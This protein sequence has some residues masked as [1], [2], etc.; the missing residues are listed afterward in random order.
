MIQPKSVNIICL[1]SWNKRIFTP[2]WVASEL[3]NLDP[4]EPYNGTINPNELEFGFSYRDITLF[5]K[6]NLIEIRL[7]KITDETKLFSVELFTR[8]MK[9]LPHTPTKGVGVNVRYEIEENANY[10]ILKD[11]KKINCSIPSFDPLQVKFGRQ[12]EDCFLNLVVE[13]TDKEKIF[14]SFNYHYPT[15]TDSLYKDVINKKISA[16]QKVLSYE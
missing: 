13:K 4:D 15:E 10:P 14:L 12:E 11:I 9:L 8:I 3:F 16:S 2:N 7:D 1:G 5:P 6:D